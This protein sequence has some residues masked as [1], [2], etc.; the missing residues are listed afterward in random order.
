MKTAEARHTVRTPPALQE[1]CSRPFSG[2]FSVITAGVAL[3]LSDRPAAR[4]RSVLHRF[5]AKPAR[6][7]EIT[8]MMA[9]VA[10]SIEGSQ[11][12]RRLLKYRYPNSGETQRSAQTL[13]VIPCRKHLSPVS[14]IN[15][16]VWARPSKPRCPDAAQ[17]PSKRHALRSWG[18][19]AGR[20][21]PSS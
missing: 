7:D 3:S 8:S 17:S 20:I 13:N 18:G 6:S 14:G 9:V 15:A 1:A 2:A 19:S 4:W 5:R 12:W 21:M 10:L 11:C 16:G